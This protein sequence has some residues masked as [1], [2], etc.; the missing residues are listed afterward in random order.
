MFL[1]TKGVSVAI[2]WLIPEVAKKPDGSIDWMRFHFKRDD[3]D[4]V[5]GISK[6]SGSTLK[7]KPNNNEVLEFQAYKK[8]LR[9]SHN[10]KLQTKGQR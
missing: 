5:L 4:S 7:L 6:A 8:P 9:P 10:R 1:R 2:A 3:Y